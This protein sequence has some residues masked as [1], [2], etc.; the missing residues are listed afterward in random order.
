MPSKFR[1]ILFHRKENPYHFALGQVHSEAPLLKS[2]PDQFAVRSGSLGDRITICNLNAENR[3]LTPDAPGVFN[4]A[5]VVSLDWGWKANGSEDRTL[6]ACG[7]DGSIKLY[8][9]PSAG[10]SESIEPSTTLKQDTGAEVVAFH[11]TTNVVTSTCGSDLNLWDLEKTT[12][13]LSLSFTAP[14]Q[15][16]SWNP[17]GSQVITV[18]K[19]NIISIC[20]PRSASKVEAQAHFGVKPSRVLWLKD[21]MCFSVGFSKSRDR[22]YRLWDSRNMSTLFM[23]KIDTSPGVMTPMYDPDSGL[24]FLAGK[25]DSMVRWFEVGASS[26]LM[27]PGIAPY[28]NPFPISYVTM[29]PKLGLDVMSGEVARLLVFNSEGTNLSQISVTVPRKS[30]M[31][32]HADIFPDTTADSPALSTNE[33]FSGE[34]KVQGKVSLDPKKRAAN[35]ATQPKSPP[36]VAA[37]IPNVPEQTTVAPPTS[38]NRLPSVVSNTLV[39]VTASM[40][41]LIVSGSNV[42]PKVETEPQTAPSPNNQSP[43]GTP[44]SA[45]K[46]FIAPRQSPYRFVQGENKNIFDGI[47]SLHTNLPNETSGFQTNSKFAAFCIAGPG[48]LCLSFFALMKMLTMLK[49]GGGRIAIWPLEKKGRLP[50]IL[51][52]IIC[53]SELGDFSFSPF[54]DHL[55]AAISEDGMIR[56]WKIPEAGIEDDSLMAATTFRAHNGRGTLLCFHP[57]VESLIASSSPETGT[58]TVKVWNLETQQ[59]IVSI[60]HPDHLFSISFHDD[61]ERMATLCRDQKVRVISLRTGEVK[62][63]GT[64]HEGSKG[65]RVM[66]LGTSQYLLTV[67]FEKRNERSLKLFDECNLENAISIT[68]LDMSPS[69]LSPFYDEDLKIIYLVGKGESVIHVLEFNGTEVSVVARVASPNASQAGYFVPKTKCD[70]RSIEIARMWRLQPSGLDE[71]SLKLPRMKKEF[72]HDDLFPPTRVAVPLSV[73]DWLKGDCVKMNFVDLKPADMETL[74]SQKAAEPVK[75]QQR[76]SVVFEPTE[77]EKKEEMMRKMR[78]RA[79]DDEAPLKQDLQEGVSDSEWD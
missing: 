24:L 34:T 71:L 49:I 15:S 65:G 21:N 29:V 13:K 59:E 54:D 17:E 58:P 11:P 75:P 8:S 56:T 27:D 73:S 14:L 50:I 55:I 62:S 33:W 78:E 18:T 61:G 28:V 37:P 7:Q 70:V 51:P 46:K 43:F 4:G 12:R 22:E 39:K 6:I 48:E 23:D 30:Y 40:P 25:G 3:R 68:N 47:K 53:G 16:F 35:S 77:A 5:P 52:A 57:T 32:F 10:L 38:V 44:S 60:A 63:T 20:D 1:N 74:S 76:V 72:F 2:S 31:D 67:G 69:L 9:I 79:R 42:A 19:D 66:W 64:A 45:R 36:S 41:K 26:R